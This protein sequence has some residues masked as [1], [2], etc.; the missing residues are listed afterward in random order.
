MN[1]VSAAV[2]T[3]FY[4]RFGGEKNEKS[5]MLVA[6]G[7]VI[8][9]GTLG[10]VFALVMAN[11]PDIK[12]PVGYLFRFHWPVW[13]RTGAACLCSRYLIDGRGAWRQ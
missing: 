1:S 2:T 10:T 9:I 8:L 6:R 5:S 3:D 12:K 4:K 7:T 11:I 13:W